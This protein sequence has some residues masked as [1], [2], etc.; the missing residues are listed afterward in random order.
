MS[1]AAVAAGLAA[2]CSVTDYREPAGELHAAIETSIDTVH[3]LDAEATAARNKRWRRNVR[4]SDAR[5]LA[6]AA[7]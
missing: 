5:R 4:Q 7:L 6:R 2:G 3:A 1:I